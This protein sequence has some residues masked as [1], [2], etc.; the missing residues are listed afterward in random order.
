MLVIEAVKGICAAFGPTIKGN[1][2]IASARAM[3]WQKGGVAICLGLTWLSLGQ[4]SLAADDQRA[5]EIVDRVARLFISQ[6]SIAT[7]EMQ[8]T[9]KDVQRK[10]SM[11]FWSLGEVEHPRPHSPARRK[12][13]AR[14]S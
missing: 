14:R 2:P 3:R 6:S 12:M 5:R 7:V 4:V 1:A 8:I 11:Q 13:R 9:K 10:I